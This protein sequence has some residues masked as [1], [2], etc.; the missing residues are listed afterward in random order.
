MTGVRPWKV[1]ADGGVSV[2]WGE[3][4]PLRPAHQDAH[5]LHLDLSNLSF[6]D[7]LFLVR[8]RG[9]L[10]WHAARGHEVIV[11]PPSRMYVR[12]YLAR[13]NICDE[14]PDRCTFNV[15]SVNSKPHPDVLIALRRLRTQ[16]DADDLDEAVENL[17]QAQFSGR[18]ARYGDA[19]TMTI[20]EMCDN[21]I[22]HGRSAHGAYVAAQRYQGKRCVLAIGDLGIGIP[23]HLRRTHPHLTD[24]GEAIA[25]ATKP[26]VT[27]VKGP[28]AQHRGNGY[29]HV[30]DEMRETA[31]P[32]GVLR[33]WAGNG[34]FSVAM[35]EGRATMRRGWT[36]EEPT[37]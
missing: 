37:A 13:M 16:R 20:G 4:L 36:I 35:T 6:V 32:S 9:F 14:L 30:I 8:L 1:P 2:K 10:D 23:E 31:V 18:L 15:G 12:N 21:A 24:D 26:R 7:P 19:F 3:W 5:P 17:L 29:F 22:S 11:E 34:R 25:E 27:G 33:V 28:R